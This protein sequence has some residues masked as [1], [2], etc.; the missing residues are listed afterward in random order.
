MQAKDASGLDFV[1]GLGDTTGG[2]A[3]DSIEADPLPH[4]KLSGVL[5]EWEMLSFLNSIP[6]V[7]KV[8]DDADVWLN[9]GLIDKAPIFDQVIQDWDVK[10]Q[11]TQAI[12]V[13][14]F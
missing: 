5:Y 1:E 9:F 10:W 13:H 3:N 4:S 12:E 8:Y 11:Q 6:V 14:C 7:G 2:H